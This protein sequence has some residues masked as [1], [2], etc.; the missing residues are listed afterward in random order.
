MKLWF[1]MLISVTFLATLTK[2]VLNQRKD[3]NKKVFVNTFGPA[4]AL[5]ILF[6]S[7]TSLAM[8]LFK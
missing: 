5:G 6:A 8:F 2:Y 7:L 1:F 4:L 3:S